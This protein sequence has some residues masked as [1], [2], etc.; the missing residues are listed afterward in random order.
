[1]EIARDVSISSAWLH[2]RLGGFHTKPTIDLISAALSDELRPHQAPDARTLSSA[3]AIAEEHNLTLLLQRLIS[4]CDDADEVLRHRLNTMRLV[5]TARALGIIVERE[6]LCK[7]IEKVDR[8]FCFLKGSATAY[9]CYTDPLVREAGDIDVLVDAKLTHEVVAI[10][11]DNGYGLVK[12]PWFGPRSEQGRKALSLVAPSGVDIDLH[13]YVAASVGHYSLAPDYP[14]TFDPMSLRPSDRVPSLES[15]FLHAAL[16]LLDNTVPLTSLADLVRLANHAE[17]SKQRCNSLARSQRLY[18]L[19]Q[20]ALTEPL[21]DTETATD[22]R[23]QGEL[24][25]PSLPDYYERHRGVGVVAAHLQV[26]RRAGPL[27][28]AE[29][30]FPSKEFLEYKNRTRVE[31]LASLLAPNRRRT[32]IHTPVGTISGVTPGPQSGNE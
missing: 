17:F 29:L 6:R 4:N 2:R 20:W 11:V 25:P 21:T 7:L 3:I 19:A 18:G 26:A 15:Q 22:R 12:A 28:Y 10:L 1:M 5:A 24:R 30:V 31:H 8:S 27:A 16:H 14:A 32:A 13:T 23:K 9:S